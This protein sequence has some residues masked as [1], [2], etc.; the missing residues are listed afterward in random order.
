MS[1]FEIQYDSRV[2]LE[3]NKLNPLPTSF[4]KDLLV[5]KT[6]THDTEYLQIDQVVGGQTMAAY[7]NRD[8]GPSKVSKSGYSSKLHVAPYV[9]EEMTLTPKDVN[10]R[11]AGM[12]EFA[13]NAQEVL[14]QR[15]AGWMKELNGRFDRLEE[16]Q[17]A[18]M[19]QT[20]QLAISGTGVSYTVDFGVQLANLNNQENLLH[21]H[22]L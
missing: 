4:L 6:E 16:K 3:A 2:L 18:E 22:W 17:I 5:T 9:Y 8:G 12:N 7:T 15:V 14:D 10:V 13:S 20:G 11:L 19:L 1:E 21:L